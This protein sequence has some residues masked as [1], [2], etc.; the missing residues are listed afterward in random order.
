MKQDQGPGISGHLSRIPYPEPSFSVLLWRAA[1]TVGLV[2]HHFVDAL[3]AFMGQC[4]A[5]A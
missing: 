5:T 3:I 2:T 1:V 4:Q